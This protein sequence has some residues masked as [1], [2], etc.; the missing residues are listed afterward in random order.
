MPLLERFQVNSFYHT[1][2]TSFSDNAQKSLDILETVFR[3]VHGFAILYI[4]DHTLQIHTATEVN[5]ASFL[6]DLQLNSLSVNYSPSAA[7]CGNIIDNVVFCHPL[8]TP[9][10]TVVLEDPSLITHYK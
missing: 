6:N 4:Y 8:Q 5:V 10:I 7:A 9:G 1:S 2:L 3:E